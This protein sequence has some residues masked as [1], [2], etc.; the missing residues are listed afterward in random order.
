M[1]YIKKQ[2]SFV[3]ENGLTYSIAFYVASDNN[4]NIY[5]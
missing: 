3:F 4:K 2:K 1:R 5:I